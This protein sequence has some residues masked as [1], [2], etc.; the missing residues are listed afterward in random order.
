ATA[1][2][3]DRARDVRPGELGPALDAL[4]AAPVPAW[5]RAHHY[6]GPRERTVL[7]LLVLDTINFSFWGGPVGY[8]EVAAALR[9]IFEAGDEL[10][11]LE[12]LATIDADHLGRLLGPL[13][14]LPDRAEALRELGRRG[15]TGLLRPT[16]VETART[17]ADSLPS[18]RDVA[19]YEGREVP[20]LKRAQILP[21][22]LHG[23]GVADVGD[24]EDLTCFADYK[25]PQV[26]RHLGTIVYSERLAER[27]DGRR[28]LA[29]GEAAEVEIRAATVQ[30]VERLRD[31]LQAGGRPLRAFEIDWMLWH[32]AQGQHPTH[33]YH[34][35]RS[36][37]Y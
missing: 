16:A 32:L 2:V 29:A 6:S 26:L 33:P 4:A 13:P 24:L 37:F 27:I 19:S 18:F 12:R 15:V 28:E 31:A 5:D 8:V 1:W 21:A 14:L 10:A 20:L 25:L 9:G 3:A 36:V 35:V 34:R 22:D 11:Q 7:Y 17:L 30:A 23:A